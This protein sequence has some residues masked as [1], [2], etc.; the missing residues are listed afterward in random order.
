MPDS[1]FHHPMKLTII[2]VNYNVKYFLEQALASVKKAAENLEAEIIVVDNASSDGSAALVKSRFPEVTLLENIVNKGFSIANNQAIKIAKGEFVLLLNPDTLLQE[3][4]LEKTVRFMD[5]HPEAGALGVNMIDGKGIFL[6]ESKRS[7]PTPAVS[8]YKIT[9]LSALFPKSKTFGRYHLGF[10]NEND[11]HEVDVLSG[12][13]M[14]IRKKTLDT[15]GLLDETFFMYGEDVDLSYRIKLAG[16]KNYYFP[17]TQIIHYKGESTK[18]GSLNYVKM[19]YNAMLIFAKKHFSSQQAKIYSIVIAVAVYLSAVAAFF[20][21]ALGQ[22]MLPFADAVLLYAGML[23]IKNFWASNIKNAPEYYPPEYMLYIVPGYIFFWLVSVYLSGGYDKPVKNHRLVRGLLTG[24]LLIAAFYAFL[25]ESLRFSRAMIILGAA[26]AVFSMVG[27]RL[28]LKMLFGKKSGVTDE[29]SH[30]MVVVGDKEE[31]ERALALLTHADSD[32]RFIGYVSPN[33]KAVED[34][35][36]LGAYDELAEIKNTYDVDEIIFC[37]KHVSAKKIIT[38]MLENGPELN[39]KIVP[40]NSASIIGS[41][42][43]NSA[44]DLF[45]IDVNLAISSPMNRRN[46]RFLDIALCC[47]FIFLLPVNIFLIK[48]FWGFIK[49]WGMVLSGSKTWVGYAGNVLQNGNYVLPKIKPGILNPIDA[50]ITKNIS[51]SAAKR[52]NLLYAKDYDAYSDLKIIWNGWKEL[53]REVG[54]TVS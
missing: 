20:K 24:S 42:S 22:I 46:K 8:F 31:A 51:D 16:Y 37:S 30:R 4:T 47:S 38:A 33:G 3:D 52:L 18:R 15:I 11:T 44:G 5:A 39:Y 54:Y 28:V 48:N 43:K 36:C 29:S 41:N 25:P 9:G 26:W 2:I 45:A 27:L 7:L 40:E 49:N 23:L 19:F 17:E 1:A 21:R 53:G 34:E 10:L 14:L 13:F 12:A 6:P 50:L 35:H 32:Y